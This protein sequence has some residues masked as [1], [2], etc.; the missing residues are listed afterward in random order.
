MGLMIFQLAL[1]AVPAAGV[2]AQ[3]LHELSTSEK[4]QELTRL[5]ATIKR[6]AGASEKVHKAIEKVASASDL[7]HKAIGKVEGAAERVKKV[8]EA[9]EKGH[10]ISE[11]G[12]GKEKGDFEMATISNLSDLMS[13]SVAVRWRNEDYI[14][15]KLEQLEYVD[16]AIDLKENVEKVLGKLPSADA[17][18]GAVREVAEEFELRLY[19]QYYVEPG[20]VTYV[21]DEQDGASRAEFEGIPRA[22]VRR[23]M[24][25]NKASM[26]I[27][28]KNLKRRHMVRFWSGNRV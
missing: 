17:V 20:K 21:L 22:V 14:D 24:D 11:A 12:E 7:A 13:D 4:L 10:T 6:L 8:S 9:A 18:K 1:A 5:G 19:V 27:E 26:L 3:T 16:P 25:L 2:L 23:F 15:E 28:H